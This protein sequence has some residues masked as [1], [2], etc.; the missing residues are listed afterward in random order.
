MLRA[1]T[2][3]LFEH[4]EARHEIKIRPAVVLRVLGDMVVIVYGQS[5]PPPRGTT[6]RIEAKTYLPDRGAGFDNATFF[7]SENVLAVPVDRITRYMGKLSPKR[8][9]DLDEL[10]SERHLQ[11]AERARSEASAQ[12]VHLLRH[13]EAHVRARH[14]H[15]DDVADEARLARAR[16]RAILHEEEFWTRA[17]L[18]ALSHVLGVAPD[19]LLGP[20]EDRDQ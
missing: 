4:K 17:E 16:L 7:A 9:M 1:G 20:D 5:K 15:V 14:T 11:L 18:H 12:R 13:I 8:F 2:T 10:T 3:V 6:L 19:V